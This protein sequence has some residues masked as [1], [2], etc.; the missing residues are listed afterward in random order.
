MQSVRVWKEFVECVDTFN[1]TC[2]DLRARTLEALRI[3]AFSEKAVKAKNSKGQTPLHFLG[4]VGESREAL[5]ILLN[6]APSAAR[7]ERC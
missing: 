2:P 5:M 6:Q 3:L 1:V 7:D 4:G